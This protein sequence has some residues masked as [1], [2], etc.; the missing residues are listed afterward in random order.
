MNSVKFR[1]ICSQKETPP[2]AVCFV[3]SVKAIE[4][5]SRFLLLCR[6]AL[7]FCWSKFDSLSEWSI[8][9]CRVIKPDSH[10]NSSTK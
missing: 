7:G 10:F 1:T 5:I 9:L 2:L 4:K 6:M 8:F 3:D